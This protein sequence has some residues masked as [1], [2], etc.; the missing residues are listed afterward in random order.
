MGWLDRAWQGT[1]IALGYAQK[2][3]VMP[4]LLET[5]V[6][7]PV[8][9]SYAPIASLA[10]V[11]AFPWV[12]ACVD[13][14]ATDLSG[15]PLRVVRGSGSEAQ[16]VEIPELAQLLRKPTSK[17]TR[18]E[19]ERQIWV[20]LL[21][22]GNAYAL[23][24]GR[25]AK[26]T[27][28][29][30][31]HPEG[32]KL[33]PGAYGFPEGYDWTPYGGSP[34][35]Y[36]ESLICHWKL[37]QWEYGPQGMAGEGLI[38]ALA[39]D[40]EADFA[41]S[42][43]SASQSRQGR[44]AAV[45]SQDPADTTAWTKEQRD[46]IGAGYTKLATENRAVMVVPSRM[47]VEFPSYSLRDMEFST[48]RGLT[49][50]TVLAAFGVPP[51]RVGLPTANYAT[52]QQQ[53][54]VYWQH[55]M[56]LA[57]ILD[58]GLSEVAAGWGTDLHVKHD[59]SGVEALQVSRDSRLNRVSTW[60]MLGAD[61]AAAAAYEGFDDAPL[62]EGQP[63]DS[64]TPSTTNAVAEWL[65]RAAPKSLDDA[66]FLADLTRSDAAT[67]EAER[68]AVWRGWLDEVHTPSERAL[69]RSVK[70]ALARQAELMAAALPEVYQEKRD[71]SA[72]LAALVDALFTPA[73]QAVLPQYTRDAYYAGTRAAFGRA[74]KQVGS[75]LAVKR[76]DPVAEQLMALMVK[77]VN[78]TTHNVVA[79]VL[80]KAIDDGASVNE[81]QTLLMQAT[82]FAPPRALAIA[83]TETTR[84]AAAGADYAWQIV[85]ADTGVSIESEWLTARD[86]AVRHDHRLMDGLIKPVGG[87]FVVPGGEF[88]GIQTSGPGDFADP[89]M[90][91]NCRC[92][93][94]PKV[95][96]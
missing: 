3:P 31:L 26:P 59:F 41:A 22:S 45:I 48:Q 44:P 14:I 42:K 78:A 88:A 40:L 96:D 19:W 94:M 9:T 39:K 23:R 91:V 2:A 25:P 57:A 38:R 72:T 50:E 89:A 85:Q 10:T 92:T 63:A 32:V 37:T 51:C 66:G 33:R 81:M 27:S 86:G 83:R 64:A 93:V 36:D 75:T 18:V 73:V 74:A 5:S 47:K 16:V 53:M 61:V 43:L 65:T 90:V 49:R 28:L 29:P 15:L 95:K 77:N 76:V 52:S 20:Y 55:L 80:Q 13:A 24:V 34:T 35:S 82:G 70:R 56:G 60:T 30:L 71:L 54:A 58:G 21:L 11:A 46:M 87:V 8:P 68:A 6:G 62:S 1:M 84:S 17:Q 12:R 7:Q 4:V 67:V 79:G 69:A